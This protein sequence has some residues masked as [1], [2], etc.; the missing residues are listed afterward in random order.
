[1]GTK[2]DRFRCPN[3]FAAFEKDSDIEMLSSGI[4][5]GGE[6]IHWSGD[7]ERDIHQIKRVVYCKACHGPIDFHALLRGHLDDR[8]YTAT[9]GWVVFFIGTVFFVA[10]R[11]DVWPGIGMSLVLGATVS[12][13]LR[14]V[15]RR[16]LKR[17]RVT[18]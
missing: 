3:C 17:W 13:M 14:L 4:A 8:P 6:G 11:D 10:Y 18:E 9:V 16:R 7:L 2:P 12:C 5:I 15:E 1:M